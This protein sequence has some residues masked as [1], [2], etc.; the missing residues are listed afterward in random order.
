[1]TA[2]RAIFSVV[3]VACLL[4]GAVLTGTFARMWFDEC[5]YPVDRW[6]ACGQAHYVLD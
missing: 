2:R 4:F 1:M 3:I 6:S 5:S